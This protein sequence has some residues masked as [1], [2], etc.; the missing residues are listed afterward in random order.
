MD[1][2]PPGSSVHAVL[3]AGRLEWVAMPSSRGPS[4]PWDWAC[5]SLCLL[6]SPAVS[7]SLVAPEV[8]HTRHDLCPVQK[9]SSQERFHTQKWQKYYF[10][11]FWFT[12]QFLFDSLPSSSFYLI[13]FASIM[14][15]TEIFWKE[16]TFS[17]P[18]TEC[19]AFAAKI[20]IW[21]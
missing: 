18:L 20:L 5:V 7:L 12:L 3:Q 6:H 13:I 11:N 17:S 16:D 9:S 8:P 4:P 15:E 19:F 2:S 10:I 1:R 21:I 14:H